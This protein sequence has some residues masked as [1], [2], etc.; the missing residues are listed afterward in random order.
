MCNFFY[1][2]IIFVFFFLVWFFCVNY[3]TRSLI[4]LFSFI[5][6][7]FVAKFWCF[8]RNWDCKGCSKDNM[9]QYIVCNNI[10]IYTNTWFI[11][12][13][14]RWTNIIRK[15]KRKKNT[16]L[17]TPTCSA[18]IVSRVF[19]E[20]MWRPKIK[21]KKNWKNKNVMMKEIDLFGFYFRYGWRW[22]FRDS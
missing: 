1:F 22:N 17:S 8:Y 6:Y 15:R 20:D 10:N 2:F 18:M 13:K 21:K 12:R 5:L 16:F 11:E 19:I 9:V 4:L 3:S 14:R 7:L